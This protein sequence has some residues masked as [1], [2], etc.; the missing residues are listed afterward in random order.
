MRLLSQSKHANGCQEPLH[1]CQRFSLI[2]MWETRRSGAPLPSSFSIMAAVSGLLESP[3][4]LPLALLFVVLFVVVRAYLNWR[5]LRQ[6]KGPLLA[7]FTSLWLFWQSACSRLSSAEFDALQQ[8]GKSSRTPIP[9]TRPLAIEY[10]V[11]TW[12]CRLAVSDWATPAS[13]QRRGPC[14]PHEC[15]GIEMEALRVV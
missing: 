8:Y 11:L 2:I 14:T 7:K 5:A 9:A 13:H 6:F 1:R 12:G 4:A 15:S 3:L 10:L